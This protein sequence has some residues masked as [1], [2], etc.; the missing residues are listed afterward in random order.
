M[1]L[2]MTAG[3]S[4]REKGNTGRDRETKSEKSQLSRNAVIFETR[5]RGL[6]KES[7]TYKGGKRGEERRRGADWQDPAVLG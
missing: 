2:K 3:V 7:S 1:A 5:T 6:R 4:K